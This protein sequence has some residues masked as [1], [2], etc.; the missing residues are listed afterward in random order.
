ME[1][2]AILFTA[3]QPGTIPLPYGWQEMR[4]GVGVCTLSSSQFPMGVMEI[5]A[6]PASWW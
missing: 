2:G 3:I 5:V 1:C 6:V 4:W